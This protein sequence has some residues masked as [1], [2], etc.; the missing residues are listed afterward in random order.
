[1]RD[2]HPEKDPSL[3][4]TDDDIDRLQDLLDRSHARS[5]EHLRSAFDQANRVSATTLVERLPGIFEMHLAVVTADGA[6]LAAPV[7]GFVLRGTICIGL[8]ERSVRAR[9]VRRDP[10][11]SAS[12]VSDTVSF[13][14]HGTAVEV[15]EAHPWFDLYDRTA[16]GLYVAQ[17]GE[18]FDDWLTQKQEREG[19]GF[20]GFIE[21]RVL[22]AK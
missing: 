19:R 3:H 16:R 2:P 22:F 21:P 8:P 5:G 13:I 11:V 18:W 10:R 20:S 6:P 12:F 9:L 14:V 15:D 1:L 4:E 17:Y 7:D